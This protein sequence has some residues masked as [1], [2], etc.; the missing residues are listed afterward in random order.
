MGKFLAVASFHNNPEEHI[1]I[2]FNNVLKQTHEDWVLIVADDFS[3]DQEFKRRLK[4]RVE[5]LN[6]NRIIY[7][8]TKKRRE[9][10]LY[11]N[12]FKWLDYDYYFDLDT[13]DILSD[14]IFEIYNNHFE[15][16]PQVSCIFSDYDKTDE[17]GNLAEMSLCQDISNYAEEFHFR[18]TYTWDEK[19]NQRFGQ[20]MFG[21]GRC[22]RRPEDDS[23]E[24]V[25]ECKTSTDS[26]FLFYNLTRGSHLHIPRK[27]YT[28]IRRDGSDSGQMSAEE[29]SDFNTNAKHWIAKYDASSDWHQ[30]SPYSGLWHLTSAMS[31]CRWIDSVDEFSI[32]SDIEDNRIKDLYPDKNITFNDKTANNVIVA[33]QPGL[34]ITGLDHCE[35]LSIFTNCAEV[36]APLDPN[37]GV[38]PLIKG[39]FEKAKE[40]IYSQVNDAS[41]YYFF[42]QSVFT[43]MPEEIEKLK[44]PQT[45]LYIVEDTT[46]K[47]ISNYNEIAQYGYDTRIVSLADY[48]EEHRDIIIRNKMENLH[49]DIVISAVATPSLHDSTFSYLSNNYCTYISSQE[50]SEKNFKGDFIQLISKVHPG[51]TLVPKCT[52][53]FRSGPELTCHSVPEGPS[54]WYAEFWHNGQMIWKQSLGARGWYRY[55]QDYWIDVE[56]RICRDGSEASYSL[57]A[58]RDANFGI[59]ID[60]ASLGD[61]LSWMGQVIELKEQ[62]SLRQIWVRC[63]KP[64]LFD[65]ER[66]RSRGI[67]IVGWDSLWPDQDQ[68]LGVFMDEANGIN[69]P[70]D[71]HP[72]DW[73]TIPLGAIAADQLGIEYRE[74]KPWLAKE[75]LEK[76]PLTKK[77]V[78]IATESTAQAKYWNHP[79]GWQ[80]LIDGLHSRDIDVLYVSKEET[81]LRG[82]E[83]IP[84]LVEAAR[85]IRG[86]GLFIGISS[87]LSWLAWALDVK[88]CMISGFTWEFVEFDCDIRIINKSVCSGCWTWAE[89]D[90]GDWNWCPQWKGTDRHFECT[91][92]IEPARVLDE[93]ETKWFSNI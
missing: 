90:R 86:A 87:G 66:Y 22:M 40:E 77:T 76:R 91:K 80:D 41:W 92:T 11:Q 58:E 37:K 32:I 34:D 61:T 53:R 3:S 28:H 62:T 68:H 10:Y 51:A 83:H 33:W 50:I 6:D 93:I 82:V 74:T 65:T 25:K 71:K 72:R 31:S 18:D 79:T 21:H 2:T 46:N 19:M 5:S 39:Y 47:W 27:L 4:K 42:R 16:Y 56:V 7:Y 15:M 75:F 26:L 81:S 30:F 69:S 78:C 48:P 63:H 73:R 8:E 49:P 57:R 59:Q 64:W 13:D 17:D 36:D 44:E 45:C 38:H 88:V 55:S 54:D 60:S 20:S 43:R 24:I 29:F 67:F 1:D 84:D 70:R 9:L 35:R 23:M 52:Y 89:F 85:A 12:F 14:K